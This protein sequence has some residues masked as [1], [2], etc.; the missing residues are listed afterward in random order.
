MVIETRSRSKDSKMLRSPDR[1]AGREAKLR[2]DVKQY[3]RTLQKISKMKTK[4][5]IALRDEGCPE[6]SHMLQTP[7]AQSRAPRCRNC[8]GCHTLDRMGPCMSCLDCRAEDDCTEHTRLCF[9]W[10]QPA[11]TFVMGST[12]TGVSSLCNAA[13]YELD[14]YKELVEKLGEA[15]L[16]VDA[17]LDQFQPARRSVQTTALIKSEERGTS[18]VKTNN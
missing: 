15:S 2:E 11:T 7:T 16:E 12:V 6:A 18:A 9:G 1:D 8:G 10:R 3:R 5:L 14:K 17:T 13:E 4:I